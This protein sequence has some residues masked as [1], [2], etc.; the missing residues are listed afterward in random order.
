MELPDIVT[1][2][3][4]VF[5]LFVLLEMVWW[6]LGH[7]LNYETRDT[8]A[9]LIMGYG[10]SIVNGATLV[11][12][13]GI[14][15]AVHQV[16]LFDI[17]YQWWAFALCFFAED[18]AYYWY[19]R[20]GHERRFFW[21]GHIAHHTSRHFNL[22]TALR[23][24]WTNLPAVSFLFWMPLAFI[25][26]PPPM[27]AFFQGLSLAYQFWIHTEAIGT[28][29]PFEWIFNTPS[30]HRV[31][32]ARQAKY[33]DANYAGVLIIWD[34]LFGSFIPEDR[35]DPPDYGIVKNLGTFNPLRIAFHEWIAMGRD[36]WRANGWRERLLY[37]FGPPGWSP[38]GSRRTTA[39]LKAE[40]R[41]G[42][43]QASGSPAGSV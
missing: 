36:L 4:P 31:H 6:R 27:I 26:I 14:F 41:A 15:T 23:Q 39:M 32:H 24:T 35:A 8:A 29:G 20:I 3:T 25:G 21:A 9:S 42:L 13:Y 2:A 18:C 11:L 16:A 1:Y 37:M 10:S 22:S 12:Y 30:H 7:G 34:R 5:I 33:L 19:H 43:A 17:G 38:D 28:M 40:W